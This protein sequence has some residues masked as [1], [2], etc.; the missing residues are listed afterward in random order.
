MR[1][2]SLETDFSQ[3]RSLAEWPT[4]DIG[5]PVNPLD[6][7]KMTGAGLPTREVPILT[8]TLGSSSKEVNIKLDIIENRDNTNLVFD[9]EY[10]GLFQEK[11]NT[12]RYLQNL[13]LR[14]DGVSLF[15]SGKED[16]IKKAAQTTSNFLVTVMLI[17]VI[18]APNTGIGIIKIFQMADF[19]L[20]FNVIAPT[21]LAA[22]VIIF[23][24]TPFDLIRHPFDF[25]SSSDGSG[26]TPPK[27]FN[28][29]E[30]SCYILSNLGQF[31]MLGLVVGVIKII[32]VAIIRQKVNDIAEKNII[33]RISVSVN[34]KL[35]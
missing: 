31:L 14:L 15:A 6:P 19:V 3:T 32:V 16:D 30:F 18:V 5:H 20:F 4:D 10:M 22:F 9:F 27:K 11:G 13:Q 12:K 7:P 28:E 26:C 8:A 23:S 34:T 17:T 24:E 1:N 35:D 29:N 21:N 2:L 25:E 33:R